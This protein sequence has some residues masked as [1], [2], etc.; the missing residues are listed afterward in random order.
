MHI[1]GSLGFL[2]RF[3]L[4]V[5]IARFPSLRRHQHPN[6]VGESFLSTVTGFLV[7]L[8]VSDLRQEVSDLRQEIFQLF[9]DLCVPYLLIELQVVYNGTTEIVVFNVTQHISILI[10]KKRCPPLLYIVARSNEG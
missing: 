7:F 9:D 2:P 1:E 3:F 6:G 4:I 8:Q 5:R 10:E